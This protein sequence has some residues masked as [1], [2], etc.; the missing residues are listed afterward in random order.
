MSS[1]K[2][3]T[4]KS[5]KSARS[6]RERMRAERAR[7]AE[8]ERRRDRLTRI[9]IAAI[10]IVV[11]AGIGVA[12]QWQRASIDT[13]ASYPQGVVFGYHDPDAK[14]TKGDADPQ[15]G[16]GAGVGHGKA[17]APVKVE[18]FEDFACPHCEEFEAQARSALDAYVNRGQVQ[19]VHYPMTLSEFGRPTELAA[20]AYACA[21]NEDQA[22]GE[23]YF[24]ALYGNYSQSWT[25]D[26]LVQ[27][28]RQVGLSSGKFR[29]C[30]SSDA[31]ATWVRSIDQ[32]ATDRGVQ[33]TPTIFVDG[34]QLPL[35]DT[36]KDGL[37][38]AIRQAL[39]DTR[40][41]K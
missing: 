27:L 37:A 5:T 17:S 18:M 13:T 9:G 38:V 23:Q 8:Q 15:P 1:R 41:K 33:A 30:V 6:A 12:V 21:V 24:D 3:G 20:N 34:K 11:I 39:H 32:T 35:E 2:S 31:F 40:A 28:G 10:V 25:E 14:P 7:R 19:V 16:L 36:S 4:A 26:Q 22:K 29:N